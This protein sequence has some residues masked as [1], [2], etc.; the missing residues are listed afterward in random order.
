MP[1]VAKLET[2]SY[3][4]NLEEVAQQTTVRVNMC[5]KRGKLGWAIPPNIERASASRE[6]KRAPPKLGTV[7]VPKK[8]TL[9]P[10]PSAAVARMISSYDD[11][12]SAFRER[13]DGLNI[14]REELD[15]VAGLAK[16]HSGKLLG[17]KQVKRF[18]SVTLGPM[19]SA[20]GCKL[21]LVEDPDQTAKIRK[22][23]WPRDS[24]QVRYKLQTEG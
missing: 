24:R 20:I 1:A 19:L 23:A 22:R 18:G 5:G 14:S 3:L 10:A 8:S 17:R 2:S 11:L 15:R 21:I 6:A 12:I 16:G 4:E 9:L 7:T 13:V